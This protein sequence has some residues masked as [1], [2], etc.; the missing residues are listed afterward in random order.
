MWTYSQRT[1]KLDHDGVTAAIGYSGNGPGKNN[2]DWQRVHNCG[3]IPQGRYTIGEPIEGTHMGPHALP[4]TP[5]T[6]NYMFGRSGFFFH[7][8]SSA[9]LGECSNGCP[10]LDAYTRGR[11]AESADREL[12]VSP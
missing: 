7:G 9:G 1:G 12:T 8:D 2:P 6:D 4:L 3:P 5:D 10:V 11:L